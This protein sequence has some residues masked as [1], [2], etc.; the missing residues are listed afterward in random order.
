MSEAR[1]ETMFQGELKVKIQGIGEFIVGLPE[2][3]LGAYF[4]QAYVVLAAEIIYGAQVEKDWEIESFSPQEKMLVICE[5]EGR[6]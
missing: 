5:R 3:T 2:G 6:K 1:W 4:M